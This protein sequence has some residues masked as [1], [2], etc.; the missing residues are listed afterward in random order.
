MADDPRDIHAEIIGRMTPE[1]KLKASMRL[2]WSARA[3]KAA[4]FRSQHPEWTEDQVKAAVR[5]A[6]LFHR[7]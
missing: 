2:Y 3:L 5:D 7:E 4:W 6:F 1:Q